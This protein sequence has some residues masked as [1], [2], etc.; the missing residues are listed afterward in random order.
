MFSDKQL[1]RYR[2][3]LEERITELKADVAGSVRQR[4]VV[5]L[6]QQSVGRLSRMDALQ[7][8]AMA[9]ATDR[10][11]HAEIAKAESALRAMQTDEFGFCLQCGEAIELGRIE[12]DPALTLCFSCAAS[13]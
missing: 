7:Q 4:N 9:Q 13:R 11:R 1:K 12:Y 10:R 2:I 8:Q 5:T 6:D 3:I